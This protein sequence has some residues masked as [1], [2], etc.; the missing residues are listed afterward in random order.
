VVHNPARGPA[1]GGIRYQ[2]DVNLDE[3]FLELECDI[4]VPAALENQITEDLNPGL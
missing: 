4:L 1:K 2:P 3:E